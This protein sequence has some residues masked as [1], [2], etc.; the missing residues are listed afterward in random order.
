MCAMKAPDSEVNDPGRDG[1]AVVHRHRHP[2]RDC[3]K[4]VSVERYGVV[5]A[6]W[7]DAEGPPVC[8]GLGAEMLMVGVLGS[9]AGPARCR[10]AS[11]RL[12][13]VPAVRLL[14]EADGLGGGGVEEAQATG[15]DGKVH[16]SGR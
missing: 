5:A 4:R 11:P 7:L 13:S 9:A 2:S 12:S 8:G 14:I 15:V 1:A 3:C 16:C 6:R 10:L